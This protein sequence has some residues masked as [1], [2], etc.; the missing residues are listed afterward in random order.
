[1]FSVVSSYL[2][3]FLITLSAYKVIDIE[4][5]AE[6][7][8]TYLELSIISLFVRLSTCIYAKLFS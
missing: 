7:Q 4:K 1:M 8:L 2:A 6:V 3:Q 5:R